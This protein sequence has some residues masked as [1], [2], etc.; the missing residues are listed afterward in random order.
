V[1]RRQSKAR[2]ASRGTDL[3]SPNRNNIP[4]ASFYLQFP[5]NP[6][7]SQRNAGLDSKQK[8]TRPPAANP[9]KAPSSAAGQG[10]L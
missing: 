10:A 5:H 7:N 9:S 1:K 4:G 3:L 8:P 2:G 6:R